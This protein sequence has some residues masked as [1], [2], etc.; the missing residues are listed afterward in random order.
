MSQF[1]KLSHAIRHCQYHFVWVPKYCYRILT[2]L[3]GQEVEKCIRAFVERLG[4]EIVELNVQEDHVHLLAMVLP[5]V[6]NSEFP[7]AGKNRLLK[8]SS[9][10][11]SSSVSS[12]DFLS[13]SSWR[14]HDDQFPHLILFTSSK[15]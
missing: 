1:R 13:L 14:C 10:I 7:S 5:K 15:K 6:S 9:D 4:A 3:V 2:G 11:F 8:P 12:V